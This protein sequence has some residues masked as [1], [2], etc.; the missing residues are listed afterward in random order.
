MELVFFSGRHTRGDCDQSPEEFTRRDWSRGLVPR[1]IHTKRFGK[2]VAGACPNN[3]NW[4]EFVGLVV[5]SPCDQI[6]KPQWPVHTI[7]LFPATCFRDQ[8]QGQ[9]VPLPFV[10]GD[11]SAF[12]RICFTSCLT[13]SL[14]FF[15]VATFVKLSD[16]SSISKTRKKVRDLYFTTT[17]IR[18][19]KGLIR[20]V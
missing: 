20:P 6:L 14:S 9:V 18:S 13:M 19:K 17:H 10:C 15:V 16:K 3:S 5:E 1:T 8:S 11:L 7:G 4:F 12:S 2:Q